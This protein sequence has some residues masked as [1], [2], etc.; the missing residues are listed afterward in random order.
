MTESDNSHHYDTILDSNS[1][2][3][4]TTEALPSTT[5]AAVVSASTRYVDLEK[6]CVYLVSCLLL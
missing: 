6:R 5:G 2:E 3:T 1:S 4:L